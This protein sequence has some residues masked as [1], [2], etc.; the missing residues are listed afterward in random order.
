LL[1]RTIDDDAEI[2]DEYFVMK[3]CERFHCLPDQLR[4]MP[5]ADFQLLIMLMSA[6]ADAATLR[7]NQDSFYSR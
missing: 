3:L 1:T 5:E 7:R 6:E 2:P 4:Q